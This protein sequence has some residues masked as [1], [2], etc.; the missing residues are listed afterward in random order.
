MHRLHSYMHMQLA[1]NETATECMA[2]EWCHMN[3]W[4][5]TWCNAATESVVFLSADNVL[6]TL[7]IY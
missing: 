3:A 5:V 6:S 2:H 4:Q 1:T 7:S